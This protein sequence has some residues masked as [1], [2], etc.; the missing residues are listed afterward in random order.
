MF[1]SG[2][3]LTECE[4]CKNRDGALFFC[5]NCGREYPNTTLPVLLLNATLA[6][7]GFGL[8]SAKARSS[9][10]LDSSL[11]FMASKS[12]SHRGRQK[13]PT[14]PLRNESSPTQDLQKFFIHFIP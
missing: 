5:P 9:H 10:F 7:V 13:R 2:L 14:E 6:V 12:R 8:A 1:R 11:A 3:S 4:P